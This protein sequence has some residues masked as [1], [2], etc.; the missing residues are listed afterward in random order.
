MRKTRSKAAFESKAVNVTIK[1]TFKTA[2][3]HEVF[4]AMVLGQ[5]R[6]IL[7]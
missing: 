2:M 4:E 5:K 3:P 6:I 1:K 7:R